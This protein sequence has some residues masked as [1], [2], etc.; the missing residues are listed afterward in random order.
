MPTGV[1]GEEAKT[2]RRIAPYRFEVALYRCDTLASE[3]VHLARAVTLARN[4]SGLAQEPKVAGNRRATDRQSVRELLHGSLPSPQKA[5]DVT[6]VGVP[7]GFEWSGLRLGHPLVPQFGVSR[8][9]ASLE[10]VDELTE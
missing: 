7:E 3:L 2:R 8:F 4:E 9:D 6:P 5:K 10:P 1:F